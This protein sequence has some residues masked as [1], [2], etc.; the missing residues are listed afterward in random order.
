MYRDQSTAASRLPM[1]GTGE[2]FED[3]EALA[4]LVPLNSTLN[5]VTPTESTHSSVRRYSPSPG[6]PATGGSR[7]GSTRSTHSIHARG[8]G[9]SAPRDPSPSPTAGSGLNLGPGGREVP[10]PNLPELHSLMPQSSHVMRGDAAYAAHLQGAG[11][12]SGAAG[13]GRGSRSPGADRHAFGASSYAGTYPAEGLR[14]YRRGHT[15]GGTPTRSQMHVHAPHALNSQGQQFHS[16][17]LADLSP[18][19]GVHVVHAHGDASTSAGVATGGF[20]G[21]LMQQSSYYDSER[22]DPAEVMGVDT[23]NQ[24]LSSGQVRTLEDT[25][26]CRCF[27]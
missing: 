10:L 7:S 21:S 16:E 8:R 14:S 26:V 19:P 18:S 11:G 22:A 5:P 4:R 27:C 23:S 24:E 13:R 2:S 25:L 1:A 17:P 20:V 6:P 9:H 12:A 3:S 15:F